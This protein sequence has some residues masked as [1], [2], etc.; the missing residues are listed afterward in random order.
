MSLYVTREPERS[1]TGFKS[2]TEGKTNAFY[3]MDDDYGCAVSGAA[4]EKTLASIADT[5]Y[6]QYL[7]AETH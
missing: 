2:V 4:P 1:Q 7:A 5:T 6:R 3:W